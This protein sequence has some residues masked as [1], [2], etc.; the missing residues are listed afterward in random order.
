MVTFSADDIANDGVA[1]EEEEE[2]TEEF[3][4][5][6]FR[7]HAVNGGQPIGAR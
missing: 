5:D 7:L 1:L 2:D 4:H 3:H 6:G